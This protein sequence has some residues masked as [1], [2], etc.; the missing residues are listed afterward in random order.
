MTELV[1]ELWEAEPH[2][3]AK[4]AILRRYLDAWFPILATHH[5][6]L[7]YF[8]GFAGPGRYSGGEE[9]SPLIALNAARRHFSR[10]R[11]SELVFVFVEQ[12]PKLAARLADEIKQLKLPSRQFKTYVVNDECQTALRKLLDQLDQRKWSAVPTFALL[13]PFGVKGLPFTLVQRLLQK[14]FCEALITFMTFAA[15]RWHGELPHHINALTGDPSAAT[16]LAESPH[17][18]ETTRALYQASLTG[19][20]RFTQCFRMRS[21][22][23]QPIYDLF[24]ATQNDL[25]FLRMKEAMWA[26]DKTG[27]FKF[28]DANDPNQTTMFEPEPELVLARG[29]LKM[30]AGQRVVYEQVE[31]YVIEKT[32][33][34]PAHAKKALHA[35]ESGP[36][37]ASAGIMV[38]EFKRDG[39]RR[40]GHYF[41]NGTFVT[42]SGASDTIS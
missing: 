39:S 28:S 2:T 25:G 5:R 36:L 32:V 26:V 12:N 17:K 18:A 13:D 31:R 15:Q 24:F 23:D 38:D 34:L 6:Q 1:D 19:V 3:R 29:L 37:S 20:A 27:Q 40:R 42:F 7:V 41:A 21:R 14:R 4:H 11:N 16:Q 35:L 10:L 22:S 9:G 8:D 33:Y 30:F